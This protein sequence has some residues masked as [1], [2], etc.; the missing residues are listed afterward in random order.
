M[1]Y[2]RL[3]AAGPARDLI[4]ARLAIG[5]EIVESLRSLA[6]KE[7]IPAAAVT[8]LGAISEVTLALYDRMTRS[9]V[10][11]HLTEEL[12]VASMVGN[13]SWLGDEPVVHLHGV[14]SRRD[15]TTAAG[16][17]MRAVV[18]VTLELMLVVYP[19]RLARKP[20]AALG[21]NLLDLP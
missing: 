7:E 20:D 9:Y 4:V 5:D 19:E 15:A 8:G 18:S 13:I 21:L 16:H 3:S 14:V 1:R 2:T 6:K 12:E 10:E 11:T 17:I